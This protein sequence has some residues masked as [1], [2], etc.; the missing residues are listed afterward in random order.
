M[1]EVIVVALVFIVSR[2]LG[3]KMVIY[4][5]ALWFVVAILAE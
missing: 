3:N 1:V 5:D 4:G 2:G